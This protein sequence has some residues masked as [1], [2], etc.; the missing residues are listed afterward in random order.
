MDGDTFD[1]EFFEDPAPNKSSAPSG[2]IVQSDEL[3]KAARRRLRF[4]SDVN[5]SGRRYKGRR[6]SRADA[7]LESQ[8]LGHCE[9]ESLDNSP[10]PTGDG[11]IASEDDVQDLGSDDRT[12][13]DVHEGDEE[14]NGLDNAA[15]SAGVF[16]TSAQ[17][18]VDN[19]ERAIAERLAAV[20]MSDMHR[21]SA[22][23]K[24]KVRILFSINLPVNAEM[25]SAHDEFLIR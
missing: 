8:S 12:E 3:T 6:V 15:F 19:E 18:D 14:I 2:S 13:A 17:R 22:V 20:K 24:Q 23:R 10:P 25:L 11:N 1:I 7:E 5:V 16:G 4:R 9:G 21:A